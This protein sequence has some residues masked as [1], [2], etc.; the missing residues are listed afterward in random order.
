MIKINRFAGIIPAIAY[1]DFSAVYLSL[2]LQGDEYDVA[3]KHE[4]GHIWLQHQYRGTAIRIEEEKNYNHQCWLLATDYEIAKHLYDKNDDVLITRPRSVLVGGVTNAMTNKYPNCIYAEDFYQELK[5]EKQQNQCNC[6]QYDEDNDTLPSETAETL[7]EK[8]KSELEKVEKAKQI[9]QSQAEINQFKPPKPSLASL[10]DRHL[11]RT[12][13][14]RVNSYRRPYRRENNTNFLK[15]GYKNKLQTPYLTLYVDRSGSF[16]ESKTAKATN[17]ITK[18][19]QKY[20]GRI[21]QDVIYFNDKLLIDDP[22]TGGGGT[23]YSAVV[24]NII[25]ERAN[26]AII[27]TDDDNYNGEKVTLPTTLVVPVGVTSTNIASKLNL[28]ELNE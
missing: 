13:I 27:I 21:N 5:K 9:N 3:Y 25:K 24:D 19:L 12:K 28:L 10:I 23:N 18:I 4:C 1:T 2:V 17:L 8:A 7:I 26:L 6:C 22:V 20:R 16:D 11:G 15:K 14:K